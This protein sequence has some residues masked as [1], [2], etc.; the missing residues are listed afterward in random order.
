MR[1][2]SILGIIAGILLICYSIW[3][4]GGFLY[5][6]PFR[7]CVGMFIG[8]CIMAFSYIIDWITLRDKIDDSRNQRYDS[9]IQEIKAM[10]ELNNL[11]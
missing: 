1:T 3:R 2:L 11:K 5:D 10:K 4:W 6:E 9:L 8:I 7:M